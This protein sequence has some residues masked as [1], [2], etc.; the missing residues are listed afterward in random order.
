[1]LRH[2]YHNRSNEL[3]ITHKSWETAGIREKMETCAEAKIELFG[4]AQY[5]VIIENTSH[6]GYFTEKIMEMFLLKTIPVYWGCS[7]INDFFNEKGIIT[8]DNV[9]DLIYKLNNLDENYYD[10]IKESIEENYNT[11]L[12]YLHVQTNII[13]KIKEIFKYNKLI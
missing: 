5:G 6:R 9:D 4:D 13:N 1:M 11:A 10:S 2:E 12:N 3:N 7:N 8:F